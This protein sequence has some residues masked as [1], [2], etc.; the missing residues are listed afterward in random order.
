MV[1]FA[2][3]VSRS[4]TV[5][6]AFLTLGVVAVVAGVVLPRIE[7]DFGATSQGVTGKLLSV[8]QLDSGR[9]IIEGPAF[10]SD[11]AS[12]V[13][14]GGRIMIGDVWDA[15]DASGFREIEGAVGSRVVQDYLGRRLFL[16]GRGHGNG[17]VA[18]P[19]LL[20]QIRALGLNPIASGKYV[21]E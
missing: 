1:V 7:G 8:T 4:D 3:V 5:D 6:V 12:E 2:M 10:A 18:S 16:L 20:A 15:L 9:F 19:E 17:Q 11:Q 21:E 14:A 13:D